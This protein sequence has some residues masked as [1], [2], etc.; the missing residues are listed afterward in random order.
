MLKQY[1]KTLVTMFWYFIS[2][3]LFSNLFKSYIDILKMF[4]DKFVKHSWNLKLK[5][6]F[7]HVNLNSDYTFLGL[8]MPQN[9]KFCCIPT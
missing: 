9:N 1:F 7:N 3:K 8:N 6:D 5:D 2:I 4:V